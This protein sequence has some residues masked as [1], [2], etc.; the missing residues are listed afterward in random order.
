M[1]RYTAEYNEVADRILESVEVHLD[2]PLPTQKRPSPNADEGIT[3][4]SIPPGICEPRSRRKRAKKDGT[5]IL[6][7]AKGNRTKPQIVPDSQSFGASMEKSFDT[8]PPHVASTKAAQNIRQ[9]SASGE[10]PGTFE[11][12]TAA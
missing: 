9:S 7:Q 12:V 2:C 5:A 10:I 4:H 8:D 1:D 11:R 6:A 3:A